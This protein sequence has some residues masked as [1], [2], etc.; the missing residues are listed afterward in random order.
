MKKIKPRI[1][2]KTGYE[3]VEILDPAAKVGPCDLRVKGRRK[4]ELW[5]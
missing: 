2:C 4:R 5:A 3:G 1:G